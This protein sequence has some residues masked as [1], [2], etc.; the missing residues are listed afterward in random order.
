MKIEEITINNLWYDDL[1]ET[2]KEYYNKGYLL[3]NVDTDC[4]VN[5]DGKVVSL[6]YS[7]KFRKQYEQ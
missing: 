4:M 7:A 3:I 1:V 5:A 2:M 6:V